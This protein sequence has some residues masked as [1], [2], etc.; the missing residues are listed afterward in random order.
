[1][2]EVRFS[3]VSVCFWDACQETLE[4]FGLLTYSVLGYSFKLEFCCLGGESGR[5]GCYMMNFV[6]MKAFSRYILV[7]V[8]C[9]SLVGS[10]LGGEAFCLTPHDDVEMSDTCREAYAHET[11][12][13]SHMPGA[14]ESHHID[15]PEICCPASSEA[16][17]GCAQIFVLPTN[18]TRTFQSPLIAAPSAQIAINSFQLSEKNII[19]EISNT[20]NPTL[21]S[22][23]T[24]ILLA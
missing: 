9:F 3:V 11:P 7:M 4:L 5:V 17:S 19:S 15:L 10:C 1:M 16:P 22:L 2:F 6:H 14:H 8:V 20:I 13:H 21:A 12:E 24:V 18:R 23:R